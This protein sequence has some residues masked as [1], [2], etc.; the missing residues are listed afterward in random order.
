M[1]A[2]HTLPES[3]VVNVT[4]QAVGV[5]LAAVPIHTEAGLSRLPGIIV[6]PVG[7]KFR[8]PVEGLT[9]NPIREVLSARA[10]VS[11]FAEALLHVAATT[12]NQ[13]TLGILAVLG[14]DVDDSIYRVRSPDRASR[15][16]DHLD[17]VNVLDQ[18]VLR[19]PIHA[20]GEG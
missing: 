4:L 20:G 18:R 3:L 7:M 10:A 13:S 16:T 12:R 9:V 6:Q 15:A 17:A 8:R 14:N 5:A 1:V 11:A 2:A 19:F